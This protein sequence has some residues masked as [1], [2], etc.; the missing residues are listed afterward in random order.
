[1]QRYSRFVFFKLCIHVKQVK[2]VLRPLLLYHRYDL[3]M[4]EKKTKTKHNY[5]KHS[6]S[7]VYNMH[8]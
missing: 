6:L 2:Q 1:M 3:L 7:Q 4:Q 5:T 8:T